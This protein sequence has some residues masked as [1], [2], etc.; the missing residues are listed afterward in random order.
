MNA[1]RF[2]LE[3]IA[4]R[5]TG[6]KVPPYIVPF[7]QVDG[8]QSFRFL[9]PK[10]SVDSKEFAKIQRMTDTE[11]DSYV[12]NNANGTP[13]MLPLTIKMEE[14]GEKS[15]LLPYEPM[16]S[17]NGSHVLIRRQVSK[18]KVRGSIKER[19]TQDDYTINVQ[20]I[21][22]GED[23]EYPTDEVERLRKHLEFG[24][25]QV[26]NPLLEVFGISHI[27]VESWSIPFTSGMSNQNYT[28]TAYSDDIY[29]LLIE[30]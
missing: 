23:G 27:V 17:I 25:L 29:K 9:D 28:F 15:W 1:S 21:I 30:D 19:W 2:V 6:L 11:L 4:A 20:G 13:M 5:I 10:A 26:W 16:I 14:Q 12:R 3:N 7:G 8:W 22:L 18:G 24:K